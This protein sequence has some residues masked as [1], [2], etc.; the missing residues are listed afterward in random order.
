MVVT[1]AGSLRSVPLSLMGLALLGVLVITAEAV[2]RT[3]IAKSA[4]KASS[5]TNYSMVLRAGGAVS[6]KLL[7]VLLRSELLKRSGWT[8]R[9]SMDVAKSED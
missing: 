6:S 8:G 9:R 1:V 7:D 3:G 2:V 5:T 4:K